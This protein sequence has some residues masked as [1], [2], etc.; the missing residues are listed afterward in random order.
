MARR[1]CTRAPTPSSSGTR[2]IRRIRDRAAN[3][4]RWDRRAAGGTGWRKGWAAR[5]DDPH[6]VGPNRQRTNRQRRAR[7]RKPSRPDLN[8]GSRPISSRRAT[9]RS[10]PTPRPGNGNAP[11]RRAD[12]RLSVSNRKSPR[13]NRRS[14]RSSRRWPRPGSTRTARPRSRSSTATR[15]DVEGWRSHAPVGRAAE[16]RPRTDDRPHVGHRR[17]PQI[18]DRTF[19]HIPCCRDAHAESRRAP[20]TA[21]RRANPRT[22]RARPRPKRLGPPAPPAEPDDRFYRH[23][24]DSMRNGI[25]AIRRDGSMAL[26]NDE[27]YRILALTRRPDDIGPTV[28]RRPARTARCLAFAGQRVRAQSADRIAPNSA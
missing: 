21:P 12:P 25:I 6:R 4:G 11:N 2:S 13:S 19:R 20:D 23:I 10:A 17:P 14:T 26:M 9:R 1:R 24:I 3:W 7:P 8:A 15:P 18:S 27:A 16:R 5:P 22:R 28:H